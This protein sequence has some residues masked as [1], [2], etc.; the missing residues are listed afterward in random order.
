MAINHL[1][2]NSRG[3]DMSQGQADKYLKHNDHIDL[4][5]D[6][7]N[8]KGYIDIGFASGSGVL[9]LGDEDFTGNGV[10]H[11]RSD[12]SPS[13]D[14]AWTLQLPATERRFAMFNDT[15]FDCTVEAGGSP[16]GNTVL[17]PDQGRA[18]LH[19]DGENVEEL[20]RD[21]YPIGFFASD[22]VYN[23]ILGAHVASDAFRLPASLPDSQAYAWNTMGGG[24]VDVVIS[25]QKNEVEVG[26]V[27][28]TAST[29]AGT[30]T[31]SS[32]QSFAAG[33]RLRLLNPA[34]NSP[35]DPTT[36]ANIAI[37]LR[38]ILT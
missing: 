24:E 38:G 30:L 34:E 26:T 15:G 13:V 11:F 28:F 2:A 27:T 18:D 23:A 3:A 10:L 36:L 20:K 14:A 6:S 22:W 7:V 5:S 25:I 4:V 37:T 31:F 1:G 12:G 19:S 16:T 8:R 29:N 21:I 9:V 35:D 32:D 33:D 17:V